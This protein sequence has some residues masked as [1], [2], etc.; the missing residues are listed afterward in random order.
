MHENRDGR[1]SPV[2][3]T[4][5]IVPGLSPETVALILVRM[6][7]VAERKQR[8]TIRAFY[9][10]PETGGAIV[11]TLDL[12]AATLVWAHFPQRPPLVEVVRSVE[13]ITASKVIHSEMKT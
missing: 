1:S 9:E 8:T 10:T 13:E 4:V 7:R 5:P 2:S 12:S 11:F 3:I 6:K